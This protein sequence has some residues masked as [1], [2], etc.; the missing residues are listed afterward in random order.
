MATKPSPAMSLRGTNSRYRLAIVPT[1]TERATPITRAPADAQKT[2]SG[3]ALCSEAKSSVAIWVLSPSSA[4]K[5]VTN[6]TS[7]SR[8]G[9]PSEAV[10][11][12]IFRYA[13][14][15]PRWRAFGNFHDSDGHQKG[16]RA[17]SYMG[18]NR[19]AGHVSARPKEPRRI[20][21]RIA[22]I[23]PL[24]EAVPPL[25]YGGTE[26]VVGHLCNSLAEMGH[27]VTLFASA[28]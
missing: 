24:T 25:L 10:C 9:S 2:A 19:R 3:G 14:A 1:S 11:W 12:N 20:K 23:A 15:P 8:M 4:T 13:P 22:Q 26:R 16:G 7:N 6:I 28:A 27:E 21:M 5:M 18:T 17:V